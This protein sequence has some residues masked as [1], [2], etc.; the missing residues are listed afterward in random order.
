MGK[1]NKIERQS[2]FEC[3]RIFA[4]VMIIFS[5]LM[6]QTGAIDNSTGIN[7]YF[8]ILTGSASRIGVSIFVMIG[9]WFMVSSEMRIS[10]ILK[11]WSEAF[12]YTTIIT[13]ILSILGFPATKL[14][15]I[16]AFFPF[17]RRPLWFV[18]AYIALMLLSPFLNEIFIWEKS[19]QTRLIITLTIIVA[20]VSTT[21]KFMDTFL[22]NVFGFVY[23]Y[24]LVGYYKFHF[25]IKGKLWKYKKTIFIVSWMFYLLLVTI[26][27][28]SFTGGNSITSLGYIYKILTQYLSDYK[29]LPNLF[30][31]SATFYY[32]INLNMGSI[33][34]INKIAE[35]A[36]GVYIIHQTPAF[37][38]VLWND[39]FK[40]GLWVNSKYFVLLSVLTV[41]LVYI[42]GSLIDHLR[43]RFIE[44]PW[45]NCRVYT[46]L[47]NKLAQ[48]LGM[49]KGRQ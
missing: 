3:C 46:I 27:W 45:V 26:K 47:S 34:I 15:L 13:V 49:E 32:F 20:I 18:G 16:S 24:V 9:A 43:V 5:H 6:G 2:N 1:T 39:I 14:Q 35:S 17:F 38:T 12:F 41:V 23:I 25:H 30:I 29:S 4:M 11:V 33:K 19:K 28:Y 31:S 7:L 8:A 48:I 44:R 21:S 42:G 37:I 22:C 36:F 10:R 40:V